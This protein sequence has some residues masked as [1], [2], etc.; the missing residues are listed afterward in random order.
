M[1]NS[2]VQVQ[3]CCI[4]ILSP[5][6]GMVSP[7]EG[8]WPSNW[9]ELNMTI[10]E[11]YPVY[12]VIKKSKKSDLHRYVMNLLYLLYSGADYR[13]SKVSAIQAASVRTLVLKTF[14]LK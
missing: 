9:P 4:F 1:V 3:K 12:I 5:N 11:R 13:Y 14:F 10:Q 8:V 6:G 2:I 7:M